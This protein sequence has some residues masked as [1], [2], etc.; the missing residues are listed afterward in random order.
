M[1]TAIESIPEDLRKYL[2]K[3]RKNLTLT[4]P[5]TLQQEVPAV[6]LFS[7]DELRFRIFDID[8]WEYYNNHH[9]P[10]K[11]PELR[12]RLRG[13]D[14][15][16]DVDDYLPDGILIWFPQFKEYGTWDGDHG[17]ITMLPGVTWTEISRNAGKY[18]NA[19]WYP[20]RVNHYL[21]RPWSDSRCKRMKPHKRHKN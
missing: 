13:I 6:G 9:E 14:L 8:T 16:K 3:N 11:D 5:G 21:L 2:A 4:W 7:L 15:I 19:Q 12:Y 10:G 17:I 18:V 20:D 1:P